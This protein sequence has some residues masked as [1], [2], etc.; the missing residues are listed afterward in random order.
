MLC[1]PALRTRRTLELVGAGFGAPTRIAFEP[2]IYEAAVGDLLALLREVPAAAGRVMLIGHQP[3]IG[4]LALSLAGAG[5][6]EQL[7]G[8][9]P[10]AALATLAAPGWDELGPGSC[11]LLEMIRPRELDG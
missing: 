4:A 8:K 6:R 11:R 9:F 1:S 3:A 7:E 5:P 2:R 10:T